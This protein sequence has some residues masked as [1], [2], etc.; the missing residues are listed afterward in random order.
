MFKSLLSCL[1]LGTPLLLHAAEPALPPGLEV[2]EKIYS[3]PA[4]ATSLESAGWA[5]LSKG[6]VAVNV[7]NGG[8][9]ITSVEENPFLELTKDLSGDTV[10]QVGIQFDSKKN[11]FFRLSF[12]DLL[13]LEYNSQFKRFAFLEKTNPKPSAYDF[14]LIQQKQGELDTFATN[15]DGFVLT[16]AVTDSKA[17]VWCD[18]LQL[19]S[20]PLENF[21]LSGHLRVRSGWHSDWSITFLNIYKLQKL[22]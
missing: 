8:L 20:V 2:G 6:E 1:V 10:I 22:P 15:P 18:Q 7:E 3:I 17:M 9:Q 14:D 16:I 11:H 5:V 19:F 21:D 12:F 4:D 13:G